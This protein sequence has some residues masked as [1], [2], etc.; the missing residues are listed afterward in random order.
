MFQYRSNSFGPSVNAIQKHLGAVEKE[1]EKMGRIAGGRASAAA[2]AAGA[3]LG[4]TISSPLS[5]MLERF[6]ARGEAASDQARRGSAIA[7]SSSGAGYGS[8]ALKLGAGYG[9][10]AL[11][12]VSAQAED[13]PLFTVGV[14]LG[15]GILIG[16]AVLG[17]VNRRAEIE[18]AA[19]SLL[20]PAR[21]MRAGGTA[22]VCRRSASLLFAGSESQRV[23]PR[24]LGTVRSGLDGS[25]IPVVATGGGKQN[26]LF[27]IARGRSARART[28]KI[29]PP[30][31]AGEGREG[32]CGRYACASVEHLPPLA[33]LHLPP[34]PL[35]GRERTYPRRSRAKFRR[36]VRRGGARGG[37][38]PSGRRRARSASAGREFFRPWPRRF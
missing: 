4:D 3:Q 2:T 17:S 14:A 23:A 25:P 8:D 38:R 35:A 11:A 26:A 7:R 37:W 21:R 19:V 27:D 15:I 20:R 34:P 9:N 18:F 1:L 36:Y 30:P 6:R 16:A 22:R 31:L 32:A 13:R 29:C 24:Q 28:D 5:D 33:S 12:R 10:D